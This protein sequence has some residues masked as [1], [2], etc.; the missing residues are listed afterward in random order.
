MVNQYSQY[1][2]L[3]GLFVNGNLTLG[4]NIADNGGILNAFNAYTAETAVPDQDYPLFFVSYAQGWCSK[5]TDAFQR[6]Q[7]QGN[8]H[9]PPKF[10]VLGPLSNF[11]QFAEVFGCPAGSP[12][13]PTVKCKVW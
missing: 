9:S 3:P 10:R 13:N 11:D 6:I 1:E 7:V 4:E 2:V 8:V 5:A 12:L